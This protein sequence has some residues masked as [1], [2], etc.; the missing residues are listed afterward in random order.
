MVQVNLGELSRYLHSSMHNC[1]ICP[2]VVS[3]THVVVLYRWAGI[4]SESHA[5][6]G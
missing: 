4:T 3:R 2:D 6:G 5:V 1:V